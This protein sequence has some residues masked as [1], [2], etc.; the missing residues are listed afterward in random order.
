M[1]DT[2]NLW[3]QA[4]ALWLGLTDDAQRA[5][6]VRAVVIGLGLSLLLTEFVKSHPII[7]GKRGQGRALYNWYI[8]AVAFAI[9]APLT[10]FLWPGLWAV[11][12]PVKV[13]FGLLIGAGASPFHQYILSPALRLLPWAR[14]GSGKGGAA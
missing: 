11:D 12:W 3:L 1:L 13:G 8:R 6:A 2:I 9:A 5:A 10:A 14:R 7:V 4:I